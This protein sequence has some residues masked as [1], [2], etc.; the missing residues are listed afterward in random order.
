MNRLLRALLA[1]VVVVG[2]TGPAIGADQKPLRKVTLMLN[3][4]PYGEHAAFY[5]G[6]DKGFFKDAGI[7]LTIQ[8]GGGSGVL[9]KTPFRRKKEQARRAKHTHSP[10]GR[11]RET[12]KFRL[13]SRATSGRHRPPERRYL[14]AF[15]GLI[16]LH[17]RTHQ[18]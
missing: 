14:P 8:P 17:V 5:Y 16:T 12:G 7:D 10:L 6:L 18:P 13:N 2:L 1:L 15:R 3:W 4:Y 11:T 9:M